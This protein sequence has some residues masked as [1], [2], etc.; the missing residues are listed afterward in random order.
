MRSKRLSFFPGFHHILSLL[1]LP[2]SIF[3]STKV[4]AD[5]APV[6]ELS[7]GELIFSQ[8][9]AFYD[10]MAGELIPL[11]ALALLASGPTPA[12]FH[13][14]VAG[15][16]ISFNQP[17]LSPQVSV[18]GLT[19][20]SYV[21]GV[22]AVGLRIPAS[23][24]FWEG[25]VGGAWF[26]VDQTLTPVSTI[27]GVYL[28]TELVLD[29][30]GPGSLDL[31]GSY[32][33]S[34]NYLLGEGRY[35]LNAGSLLEGRV[36]FYAGP[37]VIGQGNQSYEAVQAGGILSAEVLPVHTIFSL[38]AGLLNSSVWPGIGGYEGFSF[39]YSY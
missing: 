27:G 12:Y 8:Q 6:F 10:A 3:S 31:F 22:A 2:L 23:W 13:L 5:S 17:A 33:G 15:N 32:I 39:Y 35:Q 34:I 4:L 20:Q 1:L 37:E 29:R 36:L 24:G 11:P 38:E 16:V 7:G 26:N 14:F 9:A 28:Q 18:D 19:R 25:D 30:I 21:G